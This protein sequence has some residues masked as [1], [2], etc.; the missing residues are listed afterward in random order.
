VSW[1][2]PSVRDAKDLKLNWDFF[3]D[4]KNEEEERKK[5]RIGIKIVENARNVWRSLLV[6][7]ELEQKSGHKSFMSIAF[8]FPT[9]FV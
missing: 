8:C 2:L 9:R 6:V 1:A 3:F 5:S 7:A 4:K